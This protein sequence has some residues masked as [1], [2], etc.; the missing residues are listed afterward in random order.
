MW[1]RF[2]D[3]PSALENT[4]GHRQ[5]VPLRLR[6]QVQALPRVPGPRGRDHR[7]LL[8]EGGPA[9][10][11]AAAWPRA[12]CRGPAPGA[13]GLRGAPGLRAGPHREDGPRG[14]LPRGLGL[15][16]LRARSTASPWARGAARAAGSFVSYCMGITDLDPLRYDLLFERFLNPERVSM[17]DIDIDFCMRGRGGGHRLRHREVRPGQR[18]P[19]HH[20]RRDEGP[21]RHPRRGPRPG[22]APRQGGQGRQERARGP[23]RHHRAGPR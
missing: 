17:P 12:S 22:R 9:R 8:R 10:A 7:L 11:T 18:G 21:P 23:G 1:E 2:G 6:H 16:P 5:A 14:V 19:D 15:H 13:G 20:L 3:Q 4:R